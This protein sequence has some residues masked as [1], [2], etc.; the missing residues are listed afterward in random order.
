MGHATAEAI[1][2]AGLQLVPYTLTGYSSGVAVSNI[3][4]AGIPV[5]VVEPEEQQEIMDRIRASYH[6]L[7]IVDFTL[8]H[9]LNGKPFWTI[10]LPTSNVF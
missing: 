8:P 6:N 7:I 4:V 2:R 9:A 3:G 1:V 10:A 5:E